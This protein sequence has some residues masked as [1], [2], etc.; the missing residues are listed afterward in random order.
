MASLNAKLA[1]DFLRW[2]ATVHSDVVTIHADVLQL[3][4]DRL[5]GAG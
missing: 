2:K 3:M 4:K 1:A 5:S